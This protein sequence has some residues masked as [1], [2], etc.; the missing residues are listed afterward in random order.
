MSITCPN[1]Q[2]T[3]RDGARF[4]GR[5]QAPLAAAPPAHVPPGAPQS[6]PVVPLAGRKLPRI[7]KPVVTGSKRGLRFLVSIFTGGGHAAYAEVVGPAPIAD[8]TV[9]TQ[10]HESRVSYPFEIA[11]W[12]FLLA[13]PLACV[14]LILPNLLPVVAFVLIYLALIILSWAGLR[15][16]FFTTL[17]LGKVASW[18]T[19]GPRQT[20]LYR[21]DVEERQTRQR[22]TV[23]MIGPRKVPKGQS[24]GL[25]QDHRVRIYGLLDKSTNAIRAWKLEYL[26]TAWNETGVVI[27]APRFI[28][29]TSALFP[30]PTLAAL[31]GLTFV[32]L[33]FVIEAILA[34]QGGGP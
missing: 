23:T 2:H 20:T 3:N 5:C 14:V 9:A 33:R 34:A 29:L 21:F 32:V 30:P 22:I 28:P 13:W 6:P 7:P 31:G 24:T 8:G 17:T 27:K 19:R 26:D 25:Q 10:P 16:P 4:C 15:R 18:L 11:A 12:L 1:C